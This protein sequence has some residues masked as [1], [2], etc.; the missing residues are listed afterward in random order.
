MSKKKNANDL[1]SE[2]EYT[3]RMSGS[4]TNPEQDSP[5]DSE[6]DA[7]EEF[8]LGLNYNSYNDDRPEFPDEDLEPDDPRTL[9]MLEDKDF[10]V[11]EIPE[12]AMVM[13]SEQPAP[14][15]DHDSDTSTH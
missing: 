1:I 4:S 3:R 9:T 15:M 6:A 7:G 11:R 10:K 2:S 5:G 12:S 14:W 13:S 8:K